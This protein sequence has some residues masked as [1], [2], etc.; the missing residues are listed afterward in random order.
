[1]KRIA[2]LKNKKGSI[3]IIV[4]LI[5][6]L[7]SL[8]ATAMINMTIT[9]LEISRNMLLDK[10]LFFSAESGIEK[11]KAELLIKFIEKNSLKLLSGTKPDWDFVLNGSESAVPS[12]TSNNYKGGAK[13]ISDKYLCEKFYYSVTIWNNIA[14]EETG[15]CTNDTDDKIFIRCDSYLLNGPSKSIEILLQF[16]MLQAKLILCQWNRIFEHRKHPFFMF[17]FNHERKRFPSCIGEFVEELNFQTCINKNID[18]SRNWM[19]PLV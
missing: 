5:S 1:M 16:Q 3:L 12:A 9:D 19:I 4:L 10:K 18:D 8:L 2:I 11:T 17:L 15:T 7:I 6:L 14:P 13:W